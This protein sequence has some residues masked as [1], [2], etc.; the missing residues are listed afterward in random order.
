MGDRTWVSIIYAKPSEP[1]IME[2]FGWSKDDQ[3]YLNIEESDGIA[4]ASLDEVNWGGYNEMMDLAKKGITFV[5]HAG[6]GGTYGESLNIGYRGEFIAVSAYEGYPVCVIGDN[7][8]PDPKGM[9][10][11]RMFLRLQKKANRELERISDK[12]KEAA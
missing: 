3:Q 12:N 5:A 7:G 10:H 11:I 4:T 2:A 1:A 6:A 9:E 8:R